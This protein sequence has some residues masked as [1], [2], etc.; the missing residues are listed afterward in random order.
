MTTD[1]KRLA[2]DHWEWAEGLL[3]SIPEIN[4]DIE[5]FEYIYITAFIHG[6]KHGKQ[7]GE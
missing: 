6:Y 4:V 3:N 1:P 2:E 7:D 5:A